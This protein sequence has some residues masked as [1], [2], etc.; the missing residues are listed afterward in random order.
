MIKQKS[1][2][3]IYLNHSEICFTGFVVECFDFL[4]N[5]LFS[6]EFFLNLNG[7][8]DNKVVPFTDNEYGSL[9]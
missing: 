2:Q 5:T 1:L 9:I 7:L 8:S 3:F 6:N 4:T